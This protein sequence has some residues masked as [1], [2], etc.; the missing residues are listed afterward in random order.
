MRLGWSGIS[1]RLNDRRR[2]QQRRRIGA[3]LRGHVLVE[4]GRLPARPGVGKVVE[5]ARP[6]ETVVLA[7]Q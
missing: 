1:R 5:R 6:G 7:T 4:D 2:P 3:D